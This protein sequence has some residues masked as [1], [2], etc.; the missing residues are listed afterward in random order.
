MSSRKYARAVS[1]LIVGSVLATGA[2]AAQDVME[3]IVV[4]AQK[5]E[6]T[7]QEVPIA[8]SVVSA[9]T[10]EKAQINDIMDLQTVVPSLRVTQLQTSG[11]TNFLIRG[12][13]NGANNAGI[14]PSVGVFV[15]GVYRSRTAASLTDLPNL[16]RIEVLRGPQST[17]F[18]KN[19][20]AGVINIV[21]AAPDP[22]NMDAPSGSAALTFGNLSQV[23]MKGDVSM[24]LSDT[25]GLS[26]SAFSN[27][28]D[29][30]F[31]N[32]VSESHLNER[33]RWGIRADL[34]FYPS[35]RATIRVIADYDV[36]DEQCC[37]VAN[38]VDGPTGGAVR[39][40]GGNLIGEN[41]YAYEQ[42]LDFDPTNDIKNRGVSVQVD[43]DLTDD[44]LLTSITALRDLDRFENAD[45]DFTSAALVSQNTS[46][47]QLQTFTQE[48]RLSSVTSDTFS[49][50]AGIFYFD[51][52]VQQITDLD[53]GV[54]FRTYGDILAGGGVTATEQALGLPAGT[55]FA[56]G[57]GVR[58]TGGQDDRTYSLF[59]Q[60]D[61]NL[62]DRAVL[63]V[64]A[65][66]TKVEKDAYV[67][68]QNTD[69]FSGLNLVQIGFG[70]AFAAITGLAPTPANIAAVPAAAAAANA[71][72]TT[73]CTGG[74][75]P[76][77]CNALLGLRPLQFLPPFQEFPNA[78]ESGKTDEND[79]TWT[80]RLAYDAT[81]NV[82]IYVSSSTGFK[83]TSWNLSRDSRPTAAGL[84]QIRAGG[85]AVT[86]INS[87]TRFAG[88]EESTVYEIGFKGVWGQN[89]LNV[90]LFDQDIEGFQSNTFTGAAFTL[91]NAG[92]QSS[93]GIEVDTRYMLTDSLQL[94]VAG[95]FMDPKYDS[96]PNSS[97]GDL[98][99]RLPA[100]IHEAS[101]SAA[102]TYFFDVA[103]ADGF[104]R[105]NYLWESPVQVVDGIPYSIAAREVNLLN[106]SLG[107]SFDDIFEITLWGRNLMD[108]EYLLSAF[109]SVA[110]A[111]S[112]S[113]YPNQPRTFGVTLRAR[114][115]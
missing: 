103:S 86:N 14:E 52:D 50:V 6:Q 8:V 77:P 87:G 53:Y 7:L 88:P 58:E 1:A 71:I 2:G 39:A 31:K 111:G 112:F 110:Q 46:D 62:T 19:A 42:F 109:P 75:M 68:Q 113:G 16:E 96:F 20:S 56:A 63:T 51:E 26:L 21:T 105:L 24:A 64:G 49:W 60:A 84:E 92:K 17:L 3:E 40:V 36:I 89:Y 10:M 107:L 70:G 41:A 91:A 54:G 94:T 79:T 44:L 74:A 100:G 15:D 29:G 27:T 43:Y 9:D 48:L 82:N 93:R 101:I 95:T 28:R 13:G 66:Y 38:L 78:V 55:L 30:Y 18:G 67:R 12:F 4:F 102:A 98:S 76:P 59:A 61:W 57:Q 97:A 45:V 115:N 104:F 5:R 69:V 73:P 81:D 11:N 23:I 32:L 90:T 106:A 47:T 35:D 99:G 33:D 80:V 72:S 37:G 65:N 108:D 34:G 114:F 22:S 83:P 85:F 25:V